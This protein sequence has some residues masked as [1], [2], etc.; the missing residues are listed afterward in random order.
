MSIVRMLVKEIAHRKLNFLLGFVSVVAAVALLVAVLTMSGAS[1]RETTRLM[2]DMGFNIMIVPKS[3]DM[4]DFWSEDFGKE[5]MPEDYVHKLADLK[6]LMIRHLVATLQKKVTWRDRKVLLTGVLP[7]VPQKWA[8]KKPP[9]GFRI[10]RG[11]VYVGFELARGLSIRE[12][13][14]VNILGK[15]FVVERC[16]QESGSKDDI[17]I[18][19][20]LHDVQDA[21]GKPGKI[22]V[23]EALECRCKG[24]RLPN[25]RKSIAMALPDTIVLERGSIAVARAETRKMVDKYASFLI[26]TVFLICAVWVG[27]L[28]L[29]NV[30]E[31]RQEIGILRA[32][33]FR[34]GRIAA[35]FLGRAVLLGLIGAGAGFLLGTGLALRFGPLI[36]KVTSAKIIPMIGLL[37]WS[38]VGAA[39]LC[40]VAAYLPTVVAIT[41]DPAVTLREE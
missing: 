38:L 35:L 3:T 31:R 33:G 22:N 2:R 23:I 34:S 16:L 19:G 29:S 27:L 5:E 21:L 9:M 36:F 37:G 7:E 25:I 13:D 41:Q 8:D 39:A 6:A 17:R 15:D 4:A 40:A 26:P 20:H 1:Q 30:R 32:V 14:A 12:G 28:A 11:K 18:Y 24:E 10:P